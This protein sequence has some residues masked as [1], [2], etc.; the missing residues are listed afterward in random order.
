MYYGLDKIRQICYDNY[1]KGYPTYFITHN[2]LYWVTRLVHIILFARHRLL[3]LVWCDM[4]EPFCLASWKLNTDTP[5][6][7]FLMVGWWAVPAAWEIRQDLERASEQDTLR[8]VLSKHSWQ[9]KSEM[10]TYVQPQSERDKTVAGNG[11]VQEVFCIR[12]FMSPVRC[13]TLGE[14]PE[15]EQQQEV[16]SVL[17]CD[18]CFE[19][20]GDDRARGF[21]K[22]ERTW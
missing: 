11:N 21:M 7:L 16:N 4:Y 18:W 3:C 6:T 14:S 13:R 20:R 19:V 9:W 12:R 10:D 22:K 5:S 2:Y 8:P 17:W 15:S 1:G